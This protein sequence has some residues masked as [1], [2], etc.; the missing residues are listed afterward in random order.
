MAHRPE[1]IVRLARLALAAVIG[2]T[3]VSTARPLAAQEAPAAAAEPTYQVRLRDG[4]VLY[5]RIVERTDSTLVV[6]TGSGARIALQTI[7]VARV[8]LVRADAAGRAQTPDPNPTRLLF[9]PTA[10]P[11]PK[12]EGYVASYFFF[13]PMVG[14]GVTDRLVLAGGTPILPD[15]IG[16]IWYL[17]PKFTLV[18][19]DQTS[20][21]IGVLSFFSTES[22]ANNSVGILYA[23]STFGSTD[24]AVTLGAGW[25]YARID[26]SADISNRPTLLLG[27]ERRVSPSFKLVAETYSFVGGGDSDAIWALSVRILGERLAA[28]LGVAGLTAN[29]GCCLPVVDVVYS[30]GKRRE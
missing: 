18:D 6:V 5:G 16:R 22:S 7:Q 28:D 13:L 26:G 27:G 29:G 15:A 19:A 1:V 23:A 10:R 9:A 12:G 11:L 30:F 24:N 8:T 25:G 20:V 3:A 17:A 2:L 4:S 14:Y 21:A